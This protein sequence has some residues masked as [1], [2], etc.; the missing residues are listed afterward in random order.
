MKRFFLLLILV[1]I[2]AK[3]VAFAH[4]QSDS[5]RAY[6]Y[7]VHKAEHNIINKDYAD[8]RK[9]YDSAFHYLK[10]PFAVDINNKFVCCIYNGDFQSAII[11]AEILIKRGA[12]LRM[13]SAF[14]YKTFRETPQFREMVANYSRWHDEYLGNT[15]QRL[16]RT[17]RILIDADQAVHCMLPS[18]YSDSSFVAKMR[19]ND[20]SLSDVLA[21]LLLDNDFLSED[22]IGIN[23]TVDSSFSSQP[24]YGL[25]VL[26]QIQKGGSRLNKILYQAMQQGKLRPEVLIGWLSQSRMID[27]EPLTKYVVYRDT[28][29]SFRLQ[30]SGIEKA[31]SLLNDFYLSDGYFDIDERMR[32]N[33]LNFCKTC[34]HAESVS[35]FRIYPAIS[36]IGSR[37]TSSDGRLSNMSEYYDVVEHP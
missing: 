30:P 21:K 15:N 35:A 36:V 1:C 13:F 16:I 4:N 11:E 7:Y 12:S 14:R 9:S 26:H 20:D 32:F 33:Y 8:A 17:L 18:L 25:I 2:G 27:V 37:K 6:Y 28:L 3:C 10:S 29:W 24:L 5:L 34:A 23:C 31:A 22:I 19:M